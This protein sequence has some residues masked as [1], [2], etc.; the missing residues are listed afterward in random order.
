MRGIEA[1]VIEDANTSVIE[2]SI[3]VEKVGWGLWS[4]ISF[5]SI[6]GISLVIVLRMFGDDDK[7]TFT[8]NGI[9]ANRPKNYPIVNFDGNLNSFNRK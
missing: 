7:K 2:L 3:T 9:K 1:I 8:L 6:F 5:S 4:S